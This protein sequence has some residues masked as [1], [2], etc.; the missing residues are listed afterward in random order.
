MIDSLI[1]RVND[2]RPVLI[3]PVYSMMAAMSLAA[4]LE[5]PNSLSHREVLAST[6]QRA[7]TIYKAKTNDR[8]YIHHKQ[9]KREK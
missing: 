5:G 4:R 2:E 9:R 1:R 6:I 8:E 7:P 3:A